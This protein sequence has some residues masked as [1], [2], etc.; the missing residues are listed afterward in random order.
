MADNLILQIKS[1]NALNTSINSLNYIIQSVNPGL[2]KKLQEKV[3]KVIVRTFVT[4]DIIF[5]AYAL[6]SSL[7]SLPVIQEIDMTKNT[8]S[9]TGQK[10]SGYNI[11]SLNTL[12][13]SGGNNYL[14]FN[15]YPSWY[16]DFQPTG[17][18]TTAP[19]SITSV[20]HCIPTTETR[21]NQ[22]TGSYLSGGT[23]EIGRAHV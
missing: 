14:S 18:Y 20:G 1:I 7:T 9:Y 5:W 23:S 17:A 12:V 15:G 8:G 16:I 13:Q 4:S 22:T 3:R 21:A 19:I 6:D 10:N 2:L 11:N